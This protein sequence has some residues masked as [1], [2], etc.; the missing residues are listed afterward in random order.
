MVAQGMLLKGEVVCD[1]TN[2]TQLVIDQFKMHVDVYLK[3]APD[4]ENIRLQM[5][6]TKS[7]VS[8]EEL[9]ATGGNF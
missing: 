5:I 6:V 1:E 8:F 2:N 9:I 4:I 3:V 7:G